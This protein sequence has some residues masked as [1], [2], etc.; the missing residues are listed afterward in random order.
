MHTNFFLPEPAFTF[1]TQPVFWGT[2]GE[3]EALKQALQSRM[4]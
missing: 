1:L 2:E 3:N 4:G